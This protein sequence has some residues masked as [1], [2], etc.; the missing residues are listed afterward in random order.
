MSELLRLASEISALGCRYAFGVPGSG[1]TLVLADA[2]EKLG[3]SVIRTQFEGAA[4]LMAGTIGRLTGTA[5]VA[6]CIKGPGLTNMIPGL[7]VAWFENFPLVAIAEAYPPGSPPSKAHKLICH[8]SLVRAV[9]KGRWVLGTTEPSFGDLAQLAQSELPGPVLLEVTGTKIVDQAPVQ[10]KS[11]LR[12][13]DDAVLDAIRSSERPVLIVGTLG[14]RL[15]LSQRL[16]QLGIPVFST[17]AAKGV[18]DETLSHAAGVYT[19]V[20]LE[21]SPERKI[22]PDADLI[23]GI[24]LRPAE[25]LAVKPFSCRSVAL[26]PCS[27]VSGLDAFGFSAISGNGNTEEVL[28]LLQEK[29]WGGDLVAVSLAH[30]ASRLLSGPF[31]PAHAFRC[32]EQHFNGAVRM[33]LDTGYFC[34]MGEH[35]WRARKPEHCLLS[36]QAR[37]MGTALPMAIAAAI[38]D[39]QVPTVVVVGDG[40]IGPAI[41]ELRIAVERQIPL[42]IVLMTDGRFGS[43]R[44]RALKDGLSESTLT[45]GSP[46]WM[47]VMAGL[48]MS[49]RSVS[50]AA[51]LADAL[52]QWQP[53][54]GPAFLEIPFPPDPYESMVQGLR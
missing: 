20:G 36:G 43:I 8:E 41:G 35:I 38:S 32:M 14:V 49:A 29:A 51:S 11:D 47:Q 2:L 40:G 24:G 3:V 21:L 31:L 4:A 53:G 1:P 39:R 45:I 10:I 34:T 46:S 13:R 52:G 28:M 25:V 42:L 44:T 18:V 17:A 27:D 16:N 33:V 23:I 7:A 26:E 19:G 5:G 48:G 30:M 50:D 12:A 37:Y 22:L 9:S 6:F 15:Q 54:A